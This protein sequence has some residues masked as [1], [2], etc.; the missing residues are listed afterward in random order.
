MTRP[1]DL[2]KRWEEIEAQ[3]RAYRDQQRELWGD[4]DDM[5]LTRYL[6]G[7]CTED[8]ARSVEVA[9]DQ[10]P[11]VRELV[12]GVQ[13]LLQPAWVA[14]LAT[15]PVTPGRIAK[16][17][18][19]LRTSLQIWRDR[20]GRLL[21]RGLELLMVEPESLPAL[22]FAGVPLGEHE[23]LPLEGQQGT[24]ATPQQ[25][26]CCWRIPVGDAGYTLSVCASPAVAEGRWNLAVAITSDTAAPVSEQARFSIARPDDIP[27]IETTV[28][29]YTGKSIEIAG[30]MWN[31]TITVGG[32]IRVVALELGQAVR[33]P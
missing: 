6:S 1:D 7:T 27:V 8:E 15:T 5:L 4:T 22:G 3:L 9:M 24:K 26:G 29:K 16:Q 28:S 20:A 31:L 21:S 10:K 2:M 18:M 25:K 13:E 19:A 30:G 33:D 11:A 12:E 32:D 14:A 17:A 23:D